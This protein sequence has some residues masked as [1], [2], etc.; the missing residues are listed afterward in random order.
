MEDVAP[1][2]AQEPIQSQEAGDP[3]EEDG[4]EAP[5]GEEEEE[6]EE[7]EPQRVRIVSNLASCLL[8]HIHTYIP[9]L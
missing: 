8:Y 5:E 3:M 9:Y 4:E 2:S 6:E 7:E 1:A